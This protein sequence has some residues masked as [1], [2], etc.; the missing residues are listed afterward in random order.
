MTNNA[1]L[2]YDTRPSPPN[3]FRIILGDGSTKKKVEFIG[4]IDPFF[5]SK[6]KI[7]ATLYDVSF[8]PGLG[9]NIFRSI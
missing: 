5:Q 7:A 9:F 3:R 6:T 2:M 8:E 1:E 4:K